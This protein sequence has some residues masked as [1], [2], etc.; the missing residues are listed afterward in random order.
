LRQ[1]LRRQSAQV[2]AILTE[3]KVDAALQALSQFRQRVGLRGVA[4]SA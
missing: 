2:A 3:V 4:R 1:F